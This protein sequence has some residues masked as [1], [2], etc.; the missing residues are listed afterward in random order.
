[1]EF[2]GVLFKICEPVKGVSARG[3]WVKQELVFELPGE[4][5]RKVCVSFWGDKVQDAAAFRQGERVA[6]SANVES[7]EHNG[8]WFTEVRAWRVKPAGAANASAQAA[9]SG[10]DM[11]PIGA[12]KEE[13]SA[14]KNSSAEDF[15]DLP[16]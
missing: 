16:F 14:P 4:F 12:M 9:Y 7:R 15:D 5:N 10:S 1:M 2:E 3:E 8:R 6:V 13:V 11:P